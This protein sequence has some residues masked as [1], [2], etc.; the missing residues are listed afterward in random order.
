MSIVVN[1]YCSHA[2]QNKLSY[3]V[4]TRLT[5]FGAAKWTVELRGG[6]VTV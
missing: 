2:C 1:F 6:D 5:L 3:W 4:I